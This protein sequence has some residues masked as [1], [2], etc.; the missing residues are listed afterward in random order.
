MTIGGRENAAECFDVL[1]RSWAATKFQGMLHLSDGFVRFADG[2][3]VVTLAG[4]TFT[5]QTVGYLSANQ[6]IVRSVDRDHDDGYALQTIIAAGEAIFI[7][8]Y[9]SERRE[10]SSGCGSEFELFRSSSS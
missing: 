1:Q 5:Y 4:Y 7:Y 6:R 3:T 9:K 2:D 10:G 8:R